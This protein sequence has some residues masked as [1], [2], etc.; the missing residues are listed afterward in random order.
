MTNG[1]LKTC[2]RS[3]V[4]NPWPHHV[5]LNALPSGYHWRETGDDFNPKTTI[6]PAFLTGAIEV[7]IK[8]DEMPRKAYVREN[9][10]W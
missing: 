5:S 6:E 10:I 3:W 2:T 8:E 9:R 1:Y 4:D 7:V